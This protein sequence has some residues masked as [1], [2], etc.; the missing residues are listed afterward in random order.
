MLFK[1][2]YSFL[3]EIKH[4]VVR[5]LRGRDSRIHTLEHRNQEAE[6][7]SI[8]TT[9]NLNKIL[10]SGKGN[11]PEIQPLFNFKKEYSGKTKSF[12]IGQKGRLCPQIF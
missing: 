3:W 11:Q 5:N 7:L 10:I 2:Y 1:N 12:M 4:L 9:V 8:P 6:H